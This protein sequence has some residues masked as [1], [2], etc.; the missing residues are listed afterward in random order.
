MKTKCKF[1]GCE[2]EPEDVTLIESNSLKFYVCG[3]CMFDLLLFIAGWINKHREKVKKYIKY[4]E[5]LAEKL[6]KY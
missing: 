6:S 1:C 3:S 5:E 2:F 4:A